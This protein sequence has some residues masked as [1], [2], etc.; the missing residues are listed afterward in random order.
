M[1]VRRL[2]AD[3]Q[4]FE[5]NHFNLILLG[6]SFA[7]AYFILG[8]N[9]F[10]PLIDLLSGI[11]Y[12]SGFLVGL[13]Y[14]YGFTA[15]PAA[16]TIFLLAESISPFPLAI[17][18]A[19]GA[20]ISDLLLFTFVRTRVDN[21]LRYIIRHDLH[22]KIR[23]I[24][25]VMNSR[26]LKILVPVFAGLITALPL[27]N[28]FAVVLLG[29]VNYNIRKTAAMSFIFNFIGLLSIAYLGRTLL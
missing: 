11:G 27:P 2:V 24:R 22:L 18:G 12:L 9:F 26:L 1:S 10:L 15:A 29:S 19:F 14:S 28:E 25:K 21:E 23:P 6:T 17:L 3:L 5:I 16:S 7:F 13:F 8:T 20:M 4:D